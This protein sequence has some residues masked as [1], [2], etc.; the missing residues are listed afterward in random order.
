M[1]TYFIA[2]IVALMMLVAGQT[3]AQPDPFKVMITEVSWNEPDGLELTNFGPTAQ[4]LSGWCV[5]WRDASGLHG[6]LPINVVIGA[7]ESILIVEANPASTPEVPPTVPILE[8]LPV[9]STTSEGFAVAVL[10][11]QGTLVDDVA[12]TDTLGFP[13]TPISAGFRGSARR[14]QLFPSRSL[15]RIWGLDSDGGTDW[16]EEVERSFGLESR[17]SGARS[18]TDP[19][20]VQPVWINEIDTSPDY[21]ELVNRSGSSLDIVDWYFLVSD[22][23]GAPLRKVA[24]WPS[25]FVL[26]S[27]AYVVVGDGASPPPEKPATV[28]YVVLPP[29][30]LLGLSSDELTIGLYDR[31][32]RLVDLLRTIQE[33]T[34][35]VHNHPRAPSWPEDF[36]GAVPRLLAG[37]R[38]FGRTSATMDTNTGGDWR[39]VNARSMGMPNGGFVGAPGHADAYDVRL[40]EASG[41][42]ITAILNAGVVSANHR[43]SLLFSL[44][45]LD[46]QGPFFGLGGEAF[47]NWIVILSIPPLSG[48]LDELGSAR[49]DFSPGTAPSGFEMDCMFLVQ[50]PNGLLTKRTVILEFDS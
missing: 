36:H 35:V 31:L 49:F 29:A 38:A 6:S 30:G 45:H 21:V 42:G 13:V 43:Y 23:Q 48:S 4:D 44:G 10:D 27:G 46:G 15:E 26:T 18:G 1:R 12:I 22:A 50:L 25:S 14:G 37:D 20:Q 24:P 2:S 9:L 11:D 28:P 3:T 32:G 19:I 17:S 41:N 8:R 40:N 16:T 5:L 7:G 39:A 47:L 34:T 33:A